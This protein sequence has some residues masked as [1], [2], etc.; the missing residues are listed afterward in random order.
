MTIRVLGHAAKMSIQDSLPWLTKPIVVGA[1]MRVFSGPK[2]AASVT[3]AGGLG[4]IGPN[5][6]PDATLSDLTEARA[7]LRGSTGALGS[8]IDSSPNLPVGLGF[9]CWDGDLSFAAKAVAEHKP[10][11]VW[12]FAPRNGQTELD[13]WAVAIRDAHPGVS[14]WTQVGTVKESVEAAKSEAAPDVLV[15]QGAEAGGH[16]R[17]HDGMGLMT[18]LPEVADAL[19]ASGIPLVA[20]GGISDGRGIAAAVSLGASGVVMGTR[21]LASPEARISKGYQDEV[22]R[23]RDGGASTARTMLYN[24]LRG[25]T[26]WPPAFSP[27]GIVNRSWADYQA[28]VPFEELQRRYREAE[29]AGDKGWGPEGRLATYAGAGVGLIRAVEDAGELV[30]RAQGEARDVLGRAAGGV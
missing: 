2:L 13:E 25:T 4:F 27:R 15:I 23:A 18:L 1:P 21:F 5:P 24:R 6:K 14:I 28:G 19:R 20:A 10:C 26:G 30:R 3:Q 12:L 16:G 29:G 11:V 8:F 9:Q 7:L 17:A 22:I